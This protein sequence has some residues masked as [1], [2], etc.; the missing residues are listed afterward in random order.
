MYVLVV[1]V[2]IDVFKLNI[3]FCSCTE[4]QRLKYVCCLISGGKDL[5]QH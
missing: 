3:F 5:E 4:S 2:L 1:V